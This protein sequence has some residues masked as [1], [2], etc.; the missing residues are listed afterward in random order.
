MTGDTKKQ[1]IIGTHI[2]VLDKGWIVLDD[3]MKTD[4]D[5]VR[6]ARESTTANLKGTEEDKK[7]LN[8]LYKNGHVSP[9]AM[10]QICFRI[11]LPIFVMR[12]FV[13]HFSLKFNEMSSRYIKLPE[14]NF[15]PHTWRM[16]DT[17]N[18]Q[19]SDGEFDESDNQYMSELLSEQIRLDRMLEN[20]LKEAGVSKELARLTQ[21]VTQYTR[22]S[23]IGSLR[24]WLWGFLRQRLDANAQFEI[25][26]YAFGIGKYILELY[27]NTMQLFYKY[28]LG[29]V[30]VYADD[31]IEKIQEKISIVKEQREEIFNKIKGCVIEHERH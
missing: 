5:V 15:I 26:E 29:D 27:P 11:Y 19:G 23:V 24:D 12:Q 17:K 30:K 20:Q 22:I 8:Y 13:R 2:K 18:K 7:L 16:Q 31:S 14:D 1:Q 6:H 25:R 10:P 3:Y 28:T 21:N 4:L 9:F